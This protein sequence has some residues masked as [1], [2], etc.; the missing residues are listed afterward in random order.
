MQAIIL[1]GGK[2]TR[3]KPFTT[4]FP[5]PLIPINDMPILEIVLRQLKRYG[6]KDIVIT[7]NHLA[8]LIMAFFGK[9]EKLGLNIAYSIENTPLGTAGPLS[10]IET[11]DDNF[12]V[13]NGD[14]LTTL[15]F[16]NLYDYHILNRN[17]ISI[18]TYKREEKIHLGVIETENDDDFKKYIEK[19]I[20][21]FDVS[22][23]IYMVSKRMENFIPQ[24]S[25]FDMPDLITYAYDKG[26]KI[27]CYKGDY[28]WLDIGRVDDFEHA[29][30][31]FSENKKMF[32]P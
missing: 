25:K 13:M 30:E 1:A 22:M 24:N 12:L 18:S 16:K 6:F 23:G 26:C 3:L 29:N 14:I 15:D 20:Y 31:I 19:P 32:L 11:L 7:V 10:L 21:Y 17:D 8:E 2:G 28:F 5:K 27:K 4:N 9:G